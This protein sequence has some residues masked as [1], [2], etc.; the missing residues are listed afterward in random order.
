MVRGRFLGSGLSGE[1]VEY[2]CCGESY[3]VKSFFVDC[4]VELRREIFAYL[5]IQGVFPTL[6]MVSF[7]LK[8][9]ML[10][11]FPVA[12]HPYRGHGQPKRKLFENLVDDLNKLGALKMVHRDIRPDN[13]VYISVEGSERLIL[14][15]WSSSVYEN[16]KSHFEG[17]V[18]YASKEVLTQLAAGKTE[19]LYK[20]EDDL[21][22]LVKVFLGRV[23]SVDEVLLNCNDEDIPSLARHV[24]E[25]WADVIERYEGINEFFD[26]AKAKN[27]EKI[28][29]FIGGFYLWPFF[30]VSFLINMFFII[31]LFIIR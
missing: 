29:K 14:I 8:Q 23:F 3:A 20:I 22:S 12:S 10:V 13:L 6:R 4:E 30:T 21:C 2:Y 24:L 9:Q 16:V 19:V 31:L 25:I 5:I 26:A 7:D 28:K 11:L 17:T 1:V 15:D 18:R 27:Y